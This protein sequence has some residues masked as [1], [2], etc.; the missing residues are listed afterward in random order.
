MARRQTSRH[1]SI[2]EEEAPK[3]L[4]ERVTRLEDWKPAKPSGQGEGAAARLSDPQ[5]AARSERKLFL[6]LERKD[7][8]RISAQLAGDRGDIPVYFHIPSEKMTL[9]AP[10]ENWCSGREDCLQGLREAL[11]ADNVVLK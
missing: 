9:L 5:L 10:R 4:A 2:R 6:R 8:N 1:S 3:L 7:L 11:G